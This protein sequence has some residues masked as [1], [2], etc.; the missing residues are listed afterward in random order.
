MV[1]LRKTNVIPSCFY[2]L[3]FHHQARDAAV[4][5]GVWHLD[6]AYVRI[7]K[8]V[9]IATYGEEKMRRKFYVTLSQA[10]K[11]YY[12]GLFFYMQGFSPLLKI[13]IRRGSSALCCRP[14]I[15]H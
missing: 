8:V 7:Q 6:C 12:V 11:Q 1:S 15:S 5:Q 4:V 3:L 2:V 13:G 10:V 9:G 14:L